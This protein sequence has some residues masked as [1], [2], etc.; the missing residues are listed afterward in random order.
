MWNVR[1]S[2]V[3]SITNRRTKTGFCWPNRTKKRVGSKVRRLRAGLRRE[4]EE[5]RTD[6][7]DSIKRLGK[8]KDWVRTEGKDRRW[9][10]TVNWRLENTYLVLRRRVPSLLSKS[11]S[12][13]FPPSTSEQRARTY[14]VAVDDLASS[15]QVLVTQRTTI[16]HSAFQHT[17]NEKKEK[18]K[19]KE[20]GNDSPSQL[21]H[22]STT[23]TGSWFDR[24]SGTD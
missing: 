2:T 8:Q 24:R 3:F 21:L 4:Q 7:M 5:M 10:D 12:K 15:S 23:P 1:C 16:S 18:K 19:K 22:T 20:E 13:P 9:P 6:P 11:V 17:P 14:Q